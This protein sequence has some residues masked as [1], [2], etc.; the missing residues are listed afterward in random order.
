MSNNDFSVSMFDNSTLPF[1]VIRVE[2]DAEGR[3][4]DW[5]F[6]YCNQ[7]LAEIEQHPK[8]ALL[9]RRYFELYPNGDRSRLAYYAEAA[10]DNKPVELEAVNEADGKPLHINCIPVEQEGCCACLLNPKREQVYRDRLE[11]E[12]A[13]LR[14]VH[15]ALVSGAWQL[16]YNEQCELIECRWSNTLRRMLGFASVEDFPNTF[17]AWE[18][19]LHPDDK[20]YTLKEYRDTVMDFTGEKTYDVEYRVKNKNG[21]YHWYRAAGRLS[22]RADGSPVSF[23]GVFINIDEKHALHERLMRVLKEAEDAR[24]E[25]MLDHEIISAVS[26]MYFSMFR[27]DLIRDFYEEISNNNQ[28]HRLTGHEGCAQRKLNEICNTIVAEEYQDSVWKFFDLSTVAERL[29]DTDTVEIEYHAKDGNWH[30]ARFIEKKRDAQ[31]VVTHILYVTRIVSKKKQQELEKERLRIAYKAAESANEAKTTFLLNMSHDICTPM[32]AILG[33]T[34]LM[35][36]EITDPKLRHYQEMIE[37]SGSLLLSIINNVLDMA[38]IESGRMELDEDY[39]EAG[40]VISAVT[41]VFEVEAK[42]KGLHFERT[43]NVQHPHIMCD[44]TKLQEVFTNLVSNAV[45]Y[46]PSGG[47]VRISTDEL[48]CDREGWCC[49]RSTIEDNGIGMSADFL[50]HLF[51]SFTR[52][53]NTTAAGVGG[54]GLG[55]SI[56]KKLVELM[57][58]TIEVESTLG[59]GTKFTVINWHKIVSDDYAKKVNP[60]DQTG[61]ADFHGLRILLAEDNDLNAEI[62]IAILEEMGFAVD[63]AADGISCIGRLEH[64]PAGTYALILMDIQMPNMNGYKATQIIRRLPDADKANIPIVAMTANAFEEDRRTAFAAGMNGHVAKP[65]SMEVLRDT[66]GKILCNR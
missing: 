55:M 31:G 11:S 19:R 36:N 50:P 65:I 51:E 37:Q 32:N 30:E 40:D 60:P 21:A 48:P 62:A 13:A 9:G 42:K 66:L 33:Y 25:A 46:T 44:T 52:E 28:V 49:L 22:R 34:Q 1:C 3:A 56:V 23:N 24:N 41:K 58:G 57:G 35:K 16:K 15:Q 8:E 5:T 38:R 29:A 54:T 7:A 17:E 64:A 14:N 10:Y 47:T 59:K 6:L 18:S 45:K 27:I 61:Y 53:R 12:N 39:H 26:R 63:W 4:E 2:R 43:V 20:A